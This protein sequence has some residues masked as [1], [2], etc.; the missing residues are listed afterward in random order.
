MITFT[1]T[2]LSKPKLSGA[3][4]AAQ[5]RPIA[6]LPFLSKLAEQYVVELLR[7]YY[8]PSPRQFGFKERTGVADA[9]AFLQHRLAECFSGARRP[10]GVA[11]VSLDVAKA[12]DSVPFPVLEQRLAEERVPAFLRRVVAS[13]VR[14]RTA[15]VSTEEGR[16]RDFECWTG[17]P[18]GSRLGPLLFSVHLNSV[19]DLRLSSDSRLLGY[20]DDLLLVKP[21]SGQED[22]QQLQQDVD[23]IV[24]R[25]Q[26]SLGLRINGAKSS[27]LVVSFSNKESQLDLQLTAAGEPVSRVSRLRFLGTLWDDRVNLAEHWSDVHGKA[28]ALTYAL[29]TSFGRLLHP[30][31]Y[32]HVWKTRVEPVV[33]WG[34]ACTG[35]KLEASLRSVERVG[36]HAAHLAARTDFHSPYQRALP[37]LG[38]KPLWLRLLVLETGY[39]YACYAGLRTCSWIQSKVTPPSLCRRSERLASSSDSVQAHPFQ[40]YLPPTPLSSIAGL[41]LV[42]GIRAWNALEL[43]QDHPVL[44]G[45]GEAPHVY[46]THSYAY[47]NPAASDVAATTEYGE[48]IIAA[49]ARD[50]IFAP[51][52][53]P[54][55]S[56]RVGLQIL[57]NFVLWEPV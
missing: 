1:N 3:D 30:S 17:V 50:N 52:F 38:C 33:S 45:L 56:Q 19:F 11:L 27:L 42:R 28:K 40:V 44:A 46:F 32:S 49:V 39:I 47:R 4:Q 41:P 48:T 37:S 9:Q 12:F 34:F 18:Q 55:K 36:K 2:Y 26:T 13:Y 29:H 16:S 43:K 35:P 7:D 54:E 23:K 8:Q 15:Y 24:E 22:V 53:H 57:S 51:Q 20:A 6:I 10:R 14:G 25:L 5:F 21:L 31:V